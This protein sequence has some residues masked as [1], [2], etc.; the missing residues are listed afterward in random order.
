MKTKMLL[1]AVA[2]LLLA[3]ALPALAQVKAATGS[4]TGSYSKMLN[5]ALQRCGSTVAIAEVNTN[6]A[7]ENLDLLLGNAVN[8]AFL[9]TDV[10]FYTA[11]VTNMDLSEVKTLAVFHPEEVHF[12]TP[13]QSK[14][15]QIVDVQEKGRLYGTNVVKRSQA[16]EFNSVTDLA[17]YTVG[18]PQGSGASVTAK[19]IRLQSEI[20]FKVRDDFKSNDEVL[21]ALGRGEIQAGLF[22]GGAPLGTVADLPAGQWKLLTLSEE[23]VKRLSGAYKPA[24]V[25]YRN[26]N[27]LGQKTVAT[28]AVLATRTYK[29]PKMY[30]QLVALR[31][32]ILDNLDDLRETTGTHPKWQAVPQGQMTNVQ[33]RGTW[34]W[35][36]PP[37][38]TAKR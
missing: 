25:T 19:L 36:E 14:T 30:E 28:N 29:T 13:A 15:A 26:L 22:I 4:K 12:V 34:P 18:V 8:V 38:A 3:S 20:P 33:A 17:N 35:Y 2:T 16:I 23:V 5:Q 7:V 27:A 10:L 31:Q 9:Q 6:G 21:A 1:S 24:L 37:R 11:K 32:C